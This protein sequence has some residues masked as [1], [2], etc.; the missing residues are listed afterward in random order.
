MNSSS[1]PGRLSSGELRL[2]EV[3]RT[4]TL[5]V[6]RRTLAKVQWYLRLAS[7]QARRLAEFVARVKA[8][9]SDRHEAA[10]VRSF[11]LPQ[12]IVTGAWRLVYSRG[13]E[14]L[15]DRPFGREGTEW[16]YAHQIAPDV[17]EF[18]AGH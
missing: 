14:V 10:D 4:Q 6:R 9:Q 5:G 18:E 1:S 8:D 13:T 17:W 12:G 3:Q 15:W 11:P 7:S 16:F 2:R